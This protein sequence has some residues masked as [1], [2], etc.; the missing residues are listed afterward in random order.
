MA[1]VRLSRMIVDLDDPGRAPVLPG[2][3]GGARRAAESDGEFHVLRHPFLVVR[4][5]FFGYISTV[6]EHPSSLT[7]TSVTDLRLSCPG[8]EILKTYG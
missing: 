6:V 2:P 7:K 4:K 8:V 1:C 5:C 3:G